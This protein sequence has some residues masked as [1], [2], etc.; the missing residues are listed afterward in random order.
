VI[1]NT[2]II[3]KKRARFDCNGISVKVL[4]GFNT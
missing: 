4:I 3:L 1:Q 2:D